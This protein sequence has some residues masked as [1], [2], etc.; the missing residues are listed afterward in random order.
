MPADSGVIGALRSGIA[1]L[2]EAERAA[3]FIEEVFL[4]EAEP[5][6]GV[7]EDGSALVRLV[8]RAVRIHHFAH[9]E[10]AVGATAVRIDRDGFQDAIGV[11]AFSLLSRRA[12]ETPQR[13]LFERRKRVEVFQLRLAAQV[14]RRLVTVKPN[15]FEFVLSH[16]ISR[17]AQNETIALRSIPANAAAFDAADGEP[18]L[19]KHLACQLPRQRL[20]VTVL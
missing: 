14:R 13:Q 18:T 2:G 15:V 4:L 1:G 3:V 5:G 11:V 17:G 7:V 6:A 10:N 19:F 9:H 16:D 20:A 12:I 8:R